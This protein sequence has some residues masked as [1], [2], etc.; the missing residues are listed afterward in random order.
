MLGG[1][2]WARS[3]QDDRRHRQH[4]QRAPPAAHNT[5]V[6]RKPKFFDQ[7]VIEQENA[8]R[9]SML[10][11]NSRDVRLISPLQ[12][13]LVDEIMSNAASSINVLTERD[14]VMPPNSGHHCSL[15][16][17]FTF[18]RDQGGLGVHHVV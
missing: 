15:F 4:G 6:V 3:S 17:S 12:N 13:W 10:L 11:L 18:G 9:N 5:L 2:T 8:A 14:Q 1:S 7:V 16:A